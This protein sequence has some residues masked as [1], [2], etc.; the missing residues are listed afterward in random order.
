MTRKSKPHK[1]PRKV[2]PGWPIEWLSAMESIHL[3]EEDALAFA[4]AIERQPTISQPLA[5]ATRRS[6]RLSETRWCL[7]VD[8]RGR[9]TI[10]KALC[11]SEDWRGSDAIGFELLGDTPGFIMHNLSRDLR[12]ALAELE[13]LRQVRPRSAEAKRVAKLGRIVAAIAD[14]LY[15]IDQ[16]KASS[17]SAKQSFARDQAEQ[18][19]RRDGAKDP[20]DVI[21][22]ALE[23]RR[24]MHEAFP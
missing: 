10:P 17:V 23:V 9:I 12:R 18:R 3:S 7:W 22:A 2:A 1:P 16:A 21:L 6:Q 20:V 5:R 11:E 19:V 14:H 24:A 13:T 4:E 15:P 8:S